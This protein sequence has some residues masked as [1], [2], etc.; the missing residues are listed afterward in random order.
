M[1]KILAHCLSLLFNIIIGNEITLGIK[2]Q[3]LIKLPHLGIDITRVYISMAISHNA[4][5][6]LSKCDY[7]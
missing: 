4:P 1:I 3:T 5:V 2:P 7:P 6:T